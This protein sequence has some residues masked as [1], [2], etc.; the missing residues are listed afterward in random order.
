MGASIQSSIQ[1]ELQNGVRRKKTRL[2]S[3]E[4]SPGEDF[5]HSHGVQS[6]RQAAD[7]KLPPPPPPPRLERLSFQALP[8]KI[9]RRTSLCCSSAAP[10]S[11]PSCVRS[12]RSVSR[13]PPPTIPRPCWLRREPCDGPGTEKTPEPNTSSPCPFVPSMPSEP[14]ISYLSFVSGDLGDL[15][16][17]RSTVSRDAVRLRCLTPGAADVSLHTTLVSRWALDYATVLRVLSNPWATQGEGYLLTSWI[18]NCVNYFTSW[19]IIIKLLLIITFQRPSIAV[20]IKPRR[21]SL[22]CGALH[23]PTLLL[24]PPPPP[25]PSHWSVKPTHMDFF[26]LFQDA[27]KLFPLQGNLSRGF[28]VSGYLFLSSSAL[29]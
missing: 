16:P 14:F 10:R 3:T 20:S 24:S 26:P 13:P 27:E 15:V 12:P 5:R 18:N 2:K 4:P 6:R 19:I 9:S 29:L 11:H 22:V 17:C 8:D 25:S 7:S 28:V 21:P 1:A 23:S